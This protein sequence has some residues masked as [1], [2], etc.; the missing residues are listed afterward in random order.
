MKELFSNGCKVIDNI[1]GQK[2]C[3]NKI[4]LDIVFFEI[5]KKIILFMTM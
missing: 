1:E 2:D 5:K 3:W 4:L